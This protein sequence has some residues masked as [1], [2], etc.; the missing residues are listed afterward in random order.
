MRATHPVA[1]VNLVKYKSVS[2]PV[3]H[4]GKM[5]VHTPL[6][7]AVSASRSLSVSSNNIRAYRSRTRASMRGW[8]LQFYKK[9]S[10]GILITRQ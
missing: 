10:H 6:L 9:M 5:S 3:K 4:H 8:S 1:Q 2:F 7:N